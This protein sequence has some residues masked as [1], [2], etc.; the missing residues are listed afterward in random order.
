MLPCLLCPLLL[1]LASTPLGKRRLF[2]L[3]LAGCPQLPATSGTLLRQALAAGLRPCGASAL[4]LL[5]APALGP[6][7]APIILTL[8]VAVLAPPPA[9]GITRG[10]SGPPDPYARKGIPIGSVRV[11]SLVAWPVSCVLL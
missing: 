3:A 2:A 8:P 5:P 11:P 7:A 1:P 6:C 9:V 4:H 10:G